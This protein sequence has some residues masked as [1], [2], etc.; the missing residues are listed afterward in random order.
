MAPGLLV[1]YVEA[2][3]AFI[4]KAMK[5]ASNARV[6]VNQPMDCPVPDAEVS[7]LTRSNSE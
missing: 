2:K 1:L 3:E 7:G 5:Y 4:T 6:L